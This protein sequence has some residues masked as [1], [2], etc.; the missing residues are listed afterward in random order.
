[1]K[2]AKREEILQKIKKAKT[3]SGASK[4]F[5]ENP[6][7]LQKIQKEL[8]TDFIP[9]LYDKSMDKTFCAKYYEEAD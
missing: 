4:E 9:D 2:K 8:E 6:A 1:M 7:V 3:L 5:F